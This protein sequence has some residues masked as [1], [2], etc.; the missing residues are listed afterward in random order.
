METKTDLEKFSEIMN[1]AITEADA[2]MLIRMPAGT[3]EATVQCNL[4]IGPAGELY[5]LL[6]AIPTTMKKLNDM[7]KSQLDRESFAKAVCELLYKDMT[8]E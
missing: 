4:N 8:E 2:A 3:Q 5:F 6:A 1:K 7:L